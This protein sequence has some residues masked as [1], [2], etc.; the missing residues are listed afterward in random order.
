L[1]GQT[2]SSNITC[3]VLRHCV[4]FSWHEVPIV[5][6]SSWNCV[7]VFLHVLQNFRPSKFPECKQSAAPRSRACRALSEAQILLTVS[8]SDSR[9]WLESSLTGLAFVY[10]LWLT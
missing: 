4:Y 10:P 5:R 7:N 8:C 3:T 9:A 6:G 2:Y 1:R